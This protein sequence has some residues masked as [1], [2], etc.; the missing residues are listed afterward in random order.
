MKY[1]REI[2]RNHPNIILISLKKILD[3][4]IE[5]EIILNC[6]QIIQNNFKIVLK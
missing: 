1:S 5:V 6:F 3:M 2:T 4:K